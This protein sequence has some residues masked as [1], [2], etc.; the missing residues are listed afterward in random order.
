MRAWGCARGECGHVGAVGVTCVE[1]VVCVWRA[2]DV[3]G[4]YECTVRVSVVC[5][6]YVATI[7]TAPALGTH[8]DLVC[9][10]APGW[11]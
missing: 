8:A 2:G 10:L 7:A 11:W 9:G 1:S 6:F 5:V 3:C 4:L